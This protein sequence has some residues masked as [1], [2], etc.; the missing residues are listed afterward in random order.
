M[1]TKLFLMFSSEIFPKYDCM[2]S[3][4]FNKNS[5]TIAALTFCFV[6]AASQMFALCKIMVN[7]FGTDKKI[8]FSHFD[9][10]KARPGDVSDWRPDLLTSMNHI[11]AKGVNSIASNIVAIDSRNQDFS[12]MIVD[13]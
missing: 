5:K 8:S 11:Y 3:M 10:E 12:L 1:S 4:I 2:T 6:T 9:V 7:I 13:K